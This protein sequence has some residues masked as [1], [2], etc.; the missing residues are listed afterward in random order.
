MISS[1]PRWAWAAAAAMMLPGPITPAAVS[2]TESIVGAD[3]HAMAI[4]DELWVYPTGGGDR[5]SAWTT[6]DLRHWRFR[7]VILRRDAI[8]WIDDD[9]APRHYLWAPAL[10]AANGRYYLFYSVGSLVPIP[11]TQA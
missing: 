1:R 8:G 9:G 7:G 11:V 4:G 3:P 5:L 6:R 10:I 2:G